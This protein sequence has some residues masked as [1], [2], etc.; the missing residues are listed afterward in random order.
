MKQCPYCG[1]TVEENARFCLYCMKELEQKVQVSKKSSFGTKRRLR[2]ILICA[3][4]GAMLALLLPI[5]YSIRR[6]RPESPDGDSAVETQLPADPP[7]DGAETTPEPSDPSAPSAPADVQPDAEQ[8]VYTYRDAQF[9]DLIAAADRADKTL[10]AQ[11]AVVI[12]GVEQPAEGGTYVIPEQ[13]GGKTVVAVMGGTFSDATIRDTVKAVVFPAS[14]HSV[15]EKFQGCDN[16]TDL[17]VSGE[18]VVLELNV[19]SLFAN[20]SGVTLHGAPDS[21]CYYGST[22]ACTLK[23]RAEQLGLGYQEGSAR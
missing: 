15:W 5:V 3:A 23:E 9:Y 11:D 13:L 7:G 19:F 14:I 8:A 17:Y 20:P 1:A 18:S 2:V 10:L 6:E 4:L 12:T 16:L 21:I 22:G